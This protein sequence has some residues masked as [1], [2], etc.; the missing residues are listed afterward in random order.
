VDGERPR[1]PARVKGDT[2]LADVGVL[3]VHGI[4]DHQEG[5]TLTAFGEPLVD[6]L[7]E[8]L[9]GRAGA[10]A[11]GAEVTGAHAGGA[12]EVAAARLR[13]EAGSP[14]RARV[15]VS[16]HG[17]GPGAVA[18]EE[19]LFC[20]AWWG[21]SVQ[22]PSAVRLLPWLFTR[23]PLLIYWHFFLGVAAQGGRDPTPRQTWSSLVAFLLA[24]LCQL[25]VSAAMLLWLVPIGPWRRAVV[26]A[27]RTLTLTLGD[28]Y[29]LL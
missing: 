9:R 15:W 28:S 24:G 13:G 4:G 3:L 8:W 1:L 21:D 27:V 14:A 17:P 18:R 26:A 2:A 23:G 25:V 10:Q 5:Q 19:W 7:R 6:W 12:V 16:A 22:P 20:E 11:G 29:V